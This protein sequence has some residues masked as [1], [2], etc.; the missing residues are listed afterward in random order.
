[1]RITWNIEKKRGNLRPVLTYQVVLEGFEKALALPMVRVESTIPEPPSSWQPHCYP[2]EFERAGAAPAG[3]YQL[4][5]P[6][7]ARGKHG[8]TIRLPWRE[9][10]L[11]PEVEESFELLREAFEQ[12]LNAAHESEPMDEH[13]EV[14]VSASMK[15]R[16]APALL[17]DRLLSLAG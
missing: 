10:N 4:S 3:R 13:G 6:G 5:T 16:L 17:A 7:H 15:R 8:L 1:M 2:H 14:A 12:A 11:Y 9:D